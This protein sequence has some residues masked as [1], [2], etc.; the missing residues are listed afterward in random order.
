MKF[1]QMT[2]NRYCFCIVTSF[3]EIADCNGF[4]IDSADH[5]ARLLAYFG[6]G[7]LQGGLVVHIGAAGAAVEGDHGSL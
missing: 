7:G 5:S 1:K 4:K 6:C 2:G 3:L